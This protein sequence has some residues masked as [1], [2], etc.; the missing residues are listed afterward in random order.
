MPRKIHKNSVRAMLSEALHDSGKR[1]I[2]PVKIVFE[3]TV[4]YLL[5]LLADFLLLAAIRF[6]FRPGTS[7]IA[8]LWA[9]MGILSAIAIATGYVFH[10]VSSLRYQ[11]PPPRVKDQSDLIT[12]NINLKQLEEIYSDK[13]Q[14]IDEVIKQL[15]QQS[16]RNIE[17]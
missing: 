13:I 16:L 7:L 2:S 10:V 6:V 9:G 14:I 1:L 5:F 11:F 3:M 15:R 12:P 17:R 4:I 8:N